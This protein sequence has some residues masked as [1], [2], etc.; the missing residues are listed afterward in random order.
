MQA[1]ESDS[2]TQDIQIT[3]PLHFSSMRRSR[4]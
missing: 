3:L 4:F 2:T 1:V